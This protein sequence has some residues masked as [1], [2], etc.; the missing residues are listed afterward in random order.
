MLLPAVNCPIKVNKESTHISKPK[1]YVRTSKCSIR[2]SFVLFYYASIHMVLAQKTSNRCSEGYSDASLQCQALGQSSRSHLQE[3]LLPSMM[4]CTKDHGEVK[5]SDCDICVQWWTE[6]TRCA[7]GLFSAH[8]SLA[9]FTKLFINKVPL[10]KS[11]T[12]AIISVTINVRV[13][14][15]INGSSAWKALW[16]LMLLLRGVLYILYKVWTG[17][18]IFIISLSQ[19]QFL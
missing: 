4:T 19:V 3:M 13:P 7:Q 2:C 11:N 9:R 18:D 5:C 14:I 1:Q 16:T 6:R 12:F 17:D 8:D 10:L 15:F